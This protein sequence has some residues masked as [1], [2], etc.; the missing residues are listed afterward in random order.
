MFGKVDTTETYQHTVKHEVNSFLF[1]FH[2]NSL[3]S[4]SLPQMKTLFTRRY[5]GED[6]EEARTE[7]QATMEEEKEEERARRDGR[8][9]SDLPGCPA[10]MGP[11]A[12]P[13]LGAAPAASG[14]RP[15]PLELLPSPPGAR[16]RPAGR[17]P[18]PGA[19]ALGP[20]VPGLPPPASWRHP[21]CPGLEPP[22]AR[23]TYSRPLTCPGA[24][25]PLH[26]VPGPLRE[27]LRASWGFCPCN[28]LPLLFRP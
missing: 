22:G 15:L 20:R 7:T 2:S 24:R 16:S 10:T 28:P 17:L 25:T 4:R 5:R 12:R 18:G 3:E 26:R 1:E 14:A 11:G 21:G 6:R 27:C 23:A 13:R 8:E 19:R 9:V